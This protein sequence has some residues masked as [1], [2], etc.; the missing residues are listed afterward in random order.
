MGYFCFTFA[1]MSPTLQTPLSAQCSH[2]FA[3]LHRSNCA[4]GWPWMACGAQKNAPASGS[5]NHRGQDWVK[6]IGLGQI[7]RQLIIVALISTI[8]M[9]DQR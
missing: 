9:P 3:V 8:D 6:P 4:Q 1:V 7:I 5:P 2:L